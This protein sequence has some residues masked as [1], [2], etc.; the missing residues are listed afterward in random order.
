MVSGSVSVTIVPA[1]HVVESSAPGAG[2][3]GG[4][5]ST[6]YISVRGLSKTFAGRNT[7]VHA[8]AA[9]DLD[10]AE[11][12]FVSIIGPSGCGKSTLLML[13]SGLDRATAGTVRVGGR[14]IDRPTSDLGIVFQQDV[15][16]E[17]RT[18]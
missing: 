14:V 12:E 11:G 16:L 17:W 10:V 15:L 4:A 3:L 7:V 1:T 5:A 18:A 2:D 9:V 13:L 6:S 8:L